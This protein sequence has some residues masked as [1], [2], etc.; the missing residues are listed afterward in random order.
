MKTDIKAKL[1]EIESLVK[2]G[3]TEEALEKEK[4]FLEDELISEDERSE[5]FGWG[6]WVY[7]RQK[8]FKKA[9]AEA[10]KAGDNETALRCLAAIAA[11][12]YKDQEL[13]KFYT[14]QLPDSP[15]KDNPKT[16][17]AR[18]PGDDTPKEEIIRRAEKWI[19]IPEIWDPL[20]TAHLSNN[21]ARWLLKNGEGD[22]D[23]IN[24]LRFMQR[25]VELYGNEKYNLHHRASAHFWISK[26][27]E[28]LLGKE[29]A[30]PAAA[31]SVYLW[32]KQLAIDPDNKHFQD[33]LAGARKR[34]QELTENHEGLIVV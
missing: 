3:R 31:E 1:E 2:E 13:V 25:A 21:T 34:L 12:F 26:I 10:K 24:A 27:M 23:L 29:R 22:D 11:Y 17:A 9:E 28:E 4:L 32:E 7:Y 6:A 16:I 8:E 14:D 33:S 18:N 19:A 15:S 30:I 20:N 5:A